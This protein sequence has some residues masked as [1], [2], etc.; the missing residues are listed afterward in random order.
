MAARPLL[1]KDGTQHWQWRPPEWKNCLPFACGFLAFLSTRLVGHQ[2][3]HYSFWEQIYRFLYDK[4]VLSYIHSWFL[5]FGPVLFILLYD[6]RNARDFLQREQWLALFLAAGMGFGFVG[7]TDTERLQYWSMPCVYVL[8]GQAID[9]H[10][11]LFASWPLIA[12]FAIG[13]ILS[14]RILWTTPDYPTNFTHTF[15]LLQQFGSNVQLLDLFSFHGYRPKETL[16]L[17]EYLI[18]GGIVLYW[19]SWREKQINAPLH[20]TD[21]PPHRVPHIA[22]RLPQRE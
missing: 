18:F 10:R 11:T 13:Q 16:S 3:D 4:P 1:V 20:E 22:D 14:S 17:V 12:Y 15:P 8:L 9:R 21:S 19:M 2:T 5:A 7:G 6:W